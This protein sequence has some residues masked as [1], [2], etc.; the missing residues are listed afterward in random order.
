MHLYVHRDNYEHVEIYTHRNIGKGNI[1]CSLITWL[2]M[3]AFRTLATLAHAQNNGF[4]A[5]QKPFFRSLR[6]LHVYISMCI[7]F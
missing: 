1:V 7:D 3:S 4:R 5:P 6:F 2:N